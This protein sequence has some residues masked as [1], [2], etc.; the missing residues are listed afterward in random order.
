[1]FELRPFLLIIAVSC[2][3]MGLARAT[4]LITRETSELM[5]AINGHSITLHGV[6]AELACFP[7]V[8]ACVWLAWII[9]RPVLQH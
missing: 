4:A 3:I 5:I 2:L 7:F 9:V 1:M 6:Y 8:A